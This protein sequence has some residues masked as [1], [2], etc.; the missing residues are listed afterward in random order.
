MTGISQA[1][2]CKAL[3]GGFGRP[4][5]RDLDFGRQVVEYLQTLQWPEGVVVEDLSC[6][7]PLVLH[8]LQELRPAKVVLL[9]SVPRDFDPPGTLRHHQLDLTPADPARTVASLEE[10][11][12]GAVDLDHTL[13]MARHWGGLPADTVIIEVEPA[14]VGFGLG[15]SDELAGCFDPILELVRYELRGV[16]GEVGSRPDFDAGELTRPAPGSGGEVIPGP[17]AGDREPSEAVAELV[18]YADDHARARAQAGRARPLLVDDGLTLGCGVEVVGRVRPWGVFVEAGSDWFD[19]IPLESG[20]IGLVMGEVAGRGVEAAVSMSDLRA[21][22]RACAVLAGDSPATLLDQLDRLAAATGVGRGARLLYL[23]ID[24]AEGS[25]LVGSAG[26]CPPLMIGAGPP[27]ARFLALA[28]SAA[29]GQKPATGTRTEVRL[30]LGAGS[31][32]VLYTD[33]L[34]ESRSQP[35]ADGLER[36]LRAAT[37]GPGDL[38]DLCDHIVSVCAD[39][40]RDDDACLMAVRLGQ[41]AAPAVPSLRTGS[42]PG[43]R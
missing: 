9:G 31:T 20:S 5:M 38:S 13:T 7:A 6:S 22:V 17:D 15:F 29:L 37:D 43:R 34:V 33:G 14:E 8:R 10:S 11:V 39:E 16:A 26:G 18:R 36:L 3:V 1:P 23:V 19:T 12:M 25:V 40:R 41:P 32:L 28:G 24:A 21:T 30:D 35:R 4:G 27:R 2:S 42:V